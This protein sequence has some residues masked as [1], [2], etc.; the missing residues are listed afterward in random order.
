MRRFFIFLIPMI[1]FT[2]CKSK[3]ENKLN[4]DYK[5]IGDPDYTPDKKYDLRIDTL[6]LAFASNFD[7]DTINVKYNIIDTTIIITTDDVTGFAYDLRLGKIRDTNLTL[8]INRFDPVK[9]LVNKDNQLLL[10][11][12]YDSS[13]KVRSRYYLPGFY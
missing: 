1:I 2:T 8:K 3:V 9:I 7:T 4:F 13:L 12:K 5:F 10:I 11:E 6:V